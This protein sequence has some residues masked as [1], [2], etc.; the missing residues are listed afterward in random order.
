MSSCILYV[1]KEKIKAYGKYHYIICACKTNDNSYGYVIHAR[2]KEY[3][4]NIYMNKIV[5]LNKQTKL[6]TKFNKNEKI[7]DYIYNKED[8]KKIIDQLAK[9]EQRLTVSYGYGNPANLFTIK[10]SPEIQRPQYKLQKTC[11]L[12]NNVFIV[13]DWN[14]NILKKIKKHTPKNIVIDYRMRLSDNRWTKSKR[15]GSF[16]GLGGDKHKEIKFLRNFIPNFKLQ[17]EA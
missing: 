3:R 12:S 13:M 6:W 5:C 11:G 10:F 15:I 7:K 9:S 8:A 14:D 17:K 1:F 2:N 16:W 4:V